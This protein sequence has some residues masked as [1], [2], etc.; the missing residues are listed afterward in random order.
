MPLCIMCMML[1]SI[2]KPN[3]PAC[4]QELVKRISCNNVYDRIKSID[5]VSSHIVGFHRERLLPTLYSIVY[6][7]PPTYP[8]HLEH[9]DRVAEAG[10]VSLSKS[11][12]P[13]RI[14]LS[15][16]SRW[17]NV[18]SVRVFID[19][20]DYI[21]GDISDSLTND[22]YYETYV[23]V[24]G[25][26]NVGKPALS[27]CINEL[28]S[29]RSGLNPECEFNRDVLVCE[30][31]RR[32]LIVYSICMILGY[33]RAEAY[34]LEEIKKSSIISKLKESKLQDAYAILKLLK[35]SL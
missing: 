34:M 22:K 27:L 21:N 32:T 8:L 24:K 14:A 20:I 17:S 33:E 31:R 11:H 19:Y 23:S 26:I 3:V 10:L 13:R 5:L 12:P 9:H 4:Q 29:E 16:L 2:Q 6:V 25:L 18:E 15:I 1:F 28:V 30:N 7:N 35:K